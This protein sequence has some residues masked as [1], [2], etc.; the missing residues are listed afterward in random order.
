VIRFDVLRCAGG[1]SLNGAGAAVILP[2]LALVSLPGA[3]AA[4]TVALLVVTVAVL[5]PV[6]L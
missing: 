3:A 5:I 6:L 1:V 4:T 2:A